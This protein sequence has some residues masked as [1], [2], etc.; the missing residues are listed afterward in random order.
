MSQATIQANLGGYV[1]VNIAYT[2]Y[3]ITS[4]NEVQISEADIQARN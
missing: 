3:V 4:L 1:Y 2:Y